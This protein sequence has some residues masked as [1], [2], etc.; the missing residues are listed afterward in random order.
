MS[1][2]RG[3]RDREYTS[4]PDVARAFAR[5]SIGAGCAPPAGAICL[6]VLALQ[7]TASRAETST[8]SRSC[9][10]W[11]VSLIDENLCLW[12]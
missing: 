9:T 12:F 10:P 6:S 8:H 1:H 4:L 7:L 3:A 5:R 2:G 11:H